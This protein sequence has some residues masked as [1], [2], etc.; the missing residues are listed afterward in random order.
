MKKRFTLI[1]LLVVIAIIAILAAM[2]LPAL[3]RAREKAKEINCKA[4]MKQIGVGFIMYNGDYEGYFPRLWG[5]YPGYASGVMWPGYI[6]KYIHVDPAVQPQ[7]IMGPV[8]DCPS[9]TGN[10]PAVR[11]TMTY[12]SVAFPAEYVF[13]YAYNYWL[14]PGYW[15]VKTSKVQW[16]SKAMVTVEGLGS[17]G[18]SPYGTVAGK[19]LAG[20][21]HDNRCNITF[22]DGHADS[23][24]AARVNA[25][26]TNTSLNQYWIPGNKL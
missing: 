23:D 1:E 14:Q 10:L 12:Q 6:A 3:N 16:P 18:V 9:N 15:N 17:T 25:N 21:R 24:N 26:T 22:I 2:L 4:N 20:N 5:A 19:N 7:A 13:S 11:Q 8:F